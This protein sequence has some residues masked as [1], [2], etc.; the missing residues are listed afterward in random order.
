[1]FQYLK[2]VMA[3]LTHWNLSWELLIPDLTQCGTHRSTTIIFNLLCKYLIINLVS[4]LVSLVIPKSSNLPN[5]HFKLH[6]GY[7]YLVVSKLVRVCRE[8]LSNLLCKLC[9]TN[10]YN[11]PW[12]FPSPYCY[13]P[14]NN[15]FNCIARNP[16]NHCSSTWICGS[17]YC[18]NLGRTTWYK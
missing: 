18:S 2:Q 3:N 9:S 12:S 7:L 13:N 14:S 15:K 16:P 1:M 10:K 6:L 11:Y 8:L 4:Q 17:V 5:L